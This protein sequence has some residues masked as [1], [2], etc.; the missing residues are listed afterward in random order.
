[1]PPPL[2]VVL[3]MVP[4]MMSTQLIILPSKW[5]VSAIFHFFCRQSAGTAVGSRPAKGKAANQRPTDM[6]WNLYLVEMG[7][8][9]CCVRKI[10]TQ[11]IWLKRRRTKAKVTT[12]HQLASSLSQL[13][14][15]NHHDPQHLPSSRCCHGGHHRRSWCLRT[16]RYDTFYYWHS[17]VYGE[18]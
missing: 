1:M 14:N 10:S 12:A 11:D 3:S 6:I 13:F 2:M 15:K 9:T 16:R 4:M 7:V 5:M 17:I 18:L 8:H